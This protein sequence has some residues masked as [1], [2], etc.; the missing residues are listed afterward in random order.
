[1]IQDELL[2]YA[3]LTFA[4]GHDASTHG[5]HVLA[6]GQVEA[7]NEG[8]VDLPTARREHLLDG[9]KGP[10]HHAVTHAYQA[11]AAHRL[12]HLRIEQLRLRHPARLGV[13]PL[14]LA[15]GRLHP[16]AAMGEERGGVLL[17]AV[18]QEEWHTAGR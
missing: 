18:G 5:G 8:R 1:M 16:L 14:V 2:V 6:D 9:L 10:E 7:L 4:E 17:E 11:P 15:A 13:W 12:H 3:L